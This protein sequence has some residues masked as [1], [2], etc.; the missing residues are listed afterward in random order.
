MDTK[1]YFVIYGNPITKK[2]HSRIIKVGNYH[3]IIPSK[4]YV[5]YEK[6]FIKQCT[7]QRVKDMNLNK[8]Y[9]IEC[10][11]YMKT[12]RKVDLTNLLNGTMDCLV[13]ARV[14]EDDN[15]NIAYSHDGS[16]VGYDK[17]NPRVEIAIIELL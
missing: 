3:K 9:N 17:E 14:I 8:K 13:A 12:R 15:C 7:L 10:H 6:D 11:Y 16:F 5:E 4:P 2:N 1:L